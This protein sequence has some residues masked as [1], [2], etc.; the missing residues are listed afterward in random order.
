MASINGPWQSSLCR[1]SCRIQNLR[2]RHIGHKEIHS[3]VDSHRVVADSHKAVVGSRHK[4]VGSRHNAVVGSHKA[5][6][7]THNSVVGTHKAVGSVGRMAVGKVVDSRSVVGSHSV[8][9]RGFHSHRVD[10]MVV[11]TVFYDLRI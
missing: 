3:V 2:I 1:F 5:V 11:S 8:V 10:G 7:G 9:G 6:V 4:A